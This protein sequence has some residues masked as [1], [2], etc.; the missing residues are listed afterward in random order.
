M[1]P[2]NTL[3]LGFLDLLGLQQQGRNLAQLAEAVAGTIELTPFYGVYK[4]AFVIG[5]T[6]FAAAATDTQVVATVPANEYWFIFGGVAQCASLAGGTGRAG[7]QLVN[8]GRVVGASSYQSV[9]FA[10]A[11]EGVP[12]DFGW[13]VP[14]ILAPGDAIWKAGYGL[15]GAG[16]ERLNVRISYMPL[17][18]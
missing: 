6:A 7:L 3:P 5:D 11:G 17:K 1:G 12:I 9:A 16:N 13:T 4:R 10:Q 15:A 8:Q 14:P 2:I 18:G